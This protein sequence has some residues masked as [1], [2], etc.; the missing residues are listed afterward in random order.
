M[1]EQNKSTKLRE[2]GFSFCDSERRWAPFSG[3]S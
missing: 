3:R 2:A 1:H